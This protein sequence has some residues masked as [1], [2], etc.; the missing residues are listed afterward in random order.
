MFQIISKSDEPR[1]E[2]AEARRFIAENRSKIQG[3][4]NHLTGGRL[5]EVRKPFTDC[6][7]QSAGVR[8]SIRRSGE[9]DPYVRISPNRRV[10]IVDAA[11]SRQM[12]FVGEVKVIRGTNLLVLATRE[13]GFFGALDADV[14]ERLAD[15]DGFPLPDPAAEEELKSQ[16]AGRLGFA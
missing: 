5:A 3:I 7:S 11:S 16:I 13:N 1:R 12:H 4:A 15:L 9:P 2:D 10:V 14:R 6:G 8:P